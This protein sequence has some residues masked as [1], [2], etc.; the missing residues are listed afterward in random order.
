MRPMTYANLGEEVVPTAFISTD[1]IA[2][3]DT[4]SAGKPSG[5]TGAAVNLRTY[6]S[7]TTDEFDLDMLKIFGSAFSIR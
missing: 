3:V 1:S 4:R 2:A 7:L 5:T 6:N